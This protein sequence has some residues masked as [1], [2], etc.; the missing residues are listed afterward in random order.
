MYPC[1]NRRDKRSRTK[2]K[3]V[4][5]A[6]RAAFPGCRFTA[7]SSA[8]A[9]GPRNTGLGSPVNRQA[10]KP[11]LRE[12]GLTIVEILVI[13]VGVGALGLLYLQWLARPKRRPTWIMCANNLHQQSLAFKTWALDNQDRYPTQMPLTD[14]GAMEYALAAKVPPI[15]QVMSNELNTPK[16]LVCPCDP[17]RTQLTCFCT[18]LENANISYFVGVDAKDERPNMLLSGDRNLTRNGA[19]F[20]PGRL[21]TLS[22]NVRLGW[23]PD[24]HKVFGLVLLVD[25]SAWQYTGATLTVLI[26]TNRVDTNRIAVP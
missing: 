16:I 19:A 14:G 6:R 20:Q 25:G 24:I 15:F 13:I 8:V 9:T 2:T 7:L 11:A 26:Q 17:A 5:L 22:S 3:S 23:T 10:R 4:P 18:N 1:P 21:H 12:G